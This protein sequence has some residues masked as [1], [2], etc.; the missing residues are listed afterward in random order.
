MEALPYF[1][2]LVHQNDLLCSIITTGSFAHLDLTHLEH[3]FHSRHAV[4]LLN[5]SLSEQETFKS[6]MILLVES[7]TSMTFLT[8]CSTYFDHPEHYFQHPGVEQAGLPY[9]LNGVA[10]QTQKKKLGQF[11]LLPPPVPPV[12]VWVRNSSHY[13]YAIALS[14]YVHNLPALS[15]EADSVL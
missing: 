4:D 8:D 11:T 6:V 2:R 10:A 15:A 5:F 1:L 12:T 13:G 7:G 14:F 9:R 3:R